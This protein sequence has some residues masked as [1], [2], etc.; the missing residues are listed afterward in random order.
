METEARTAQEEAARLVPVEFV[1]E[2]G[3]VA[4][5]DGLAA[6]EQRDL[7]VEIVQNFDER[8]LEAGDLES[9]LDTPYQTDWVDLCTDILEQA[10]N[11][12]CITVVRWSVQS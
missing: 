8:A 1:D 4:G 10:A 9:V 6:L 11:E 5:E 7:E 3:A 12:R 2:V